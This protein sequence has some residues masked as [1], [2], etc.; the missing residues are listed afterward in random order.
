MPT[1]RV[2]TTGATFAPARAPTRRGA[3]VRRV[4]SSHQPTSTSDA[5]LNAS[6]RSPRSASPPM[7]RSTRG[8]RATA[9]PGVGAALVVVGDDGE[10][11]AATVNGGEVNAA[12]APEET[13]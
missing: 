4:L 13:A 12:V 9:A 6:T 5:P 8:G 10:L 1:E 2:A 11:T 7:A 3:R